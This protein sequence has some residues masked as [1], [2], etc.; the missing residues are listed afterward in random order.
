MAADAG[1]ID[2][3]SFEGLQF[4]QFIE[5]TFLFFEWDLVECDAMNCGAE[6]CHSF[7]DPKDGEIFNA[8]DIAAEVEW[9]FAFAELRE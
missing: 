8:G 7:N 6:I 2:A 5:A 1:V 9:I 4:E 3:G